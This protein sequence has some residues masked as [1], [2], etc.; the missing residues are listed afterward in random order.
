[1]LFKGQWCSKVNALRKREEFTVRE[2]ILLKLSEAEGIRRS[3]VV[4][5]PLVNVTQP[6]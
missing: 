5:V 4:T 1:M 2:K 6:R 3:S